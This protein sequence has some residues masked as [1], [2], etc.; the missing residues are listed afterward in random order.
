LVF[1]KYWFFIANFSGKGGM[2]VKLL[3]HRYFLFMITFL[4]AIISL[5][6]LVREILFLLK[7]EEVDSLEKLFLD[8]ETLAVLFVGIGV[9]LKGREVF[10]G[11]ASKVT[12]KERSSQDE[13]LD[14]QCAYYGIMICSIG[15]LIEIVDQ[16]MGFFV[17]SPYF[18][19]GIQLGINFPLNIYGFVLLTI[20]AGK[21]LKYDPPKMV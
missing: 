18:S 9:L 2:V 4:S 12:G 3:A 16:M 20:I 5:R 8:E 21:L 1:I 13:E 15:F 10:T 6:L 7:V 17:N 19:L 11:E 14:D